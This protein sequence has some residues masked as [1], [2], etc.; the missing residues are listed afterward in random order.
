MNEKYIF[1]EIVPLPIPVE[2]NGHHIMD[3]PFLDYHRSRLS[4][5]VYRP[6]EKSTSMIVAYERDSAIG[7]K[8]LKD[9]KINLPTSVRGGTLGDPIELKP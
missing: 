2:A 3:I 5:K 8:D 4:G 9:A 6:S 7:K 1:F